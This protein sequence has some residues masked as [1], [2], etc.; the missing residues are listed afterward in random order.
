[1]TKLSIFD[2]YE[3]TVTA[4]GQVTIEGGP[5][6]NLPGQWVGRLPGAYSDFAHRN[7]FL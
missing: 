5:Q 2:L 6:N 3:G 1:V 4:G 7:G